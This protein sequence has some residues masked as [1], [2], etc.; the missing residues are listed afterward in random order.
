[1]TVVVVIIVVYIIAPHRNRIIAADCALYVFMREENMDGFFGGGGRGMALVSKTT[2]VVEG[3]TV[4]LL[5]NANLEWDL[6]KERG[7]MFNLHASNQRNSFYWIR[8]SSCVRAL[9]QHF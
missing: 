2:I 7:G 4:T 1:M 8:N 9:A 6:K 5:M 3:C